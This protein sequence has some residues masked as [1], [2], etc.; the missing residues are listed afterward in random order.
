[1]RSPDPAQLADQLRGV[2]EPVVVGAGLEI[3][4]VEVR[5]AGRRHAVKLVVDL[6]EG[7]TATG[8]DLD[9]I[10]RLSRTAAAELDPHEHLIEGSYTLEVTSPGVDRPLTRPRHWRRNFLRLARITLAG[11]DSIDARIGRADDER[12]Q[13]AVPGRKEPELREI[14]YSDVAHA[15]VQV[16]FKPAP[17][18]ETALLGADG[19]GADGVISESSTS[20]ETSADEENR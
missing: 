15:Q 18:A 11:G 13:V 20:S 2:L 14:A 1:M 9:D 5:T 17:K 6:P 12:V 10:A 8:I 7:S 19:A 3:D 4:A 16:E